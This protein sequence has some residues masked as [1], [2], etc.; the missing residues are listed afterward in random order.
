M[1]AVKVS[2]LVLLTV[3]LSANCHAPPVPLNVRSEAK[4][5]ALVVMVLLLVA[6]KVIAPV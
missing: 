5:T 1:P 4:G 3:R 2:V 6:L